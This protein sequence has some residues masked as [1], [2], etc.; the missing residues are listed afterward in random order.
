MKSNES[1]QAPAA[2]SRAEVADRLGVSTQTVDALRDK[3]ELPFVKLGRRVLI[4]A[5]DVDRWLARAA[6]TGGD[7]ATR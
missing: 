6:L 4:Q 2:L 5:A 3:G 7:H 1:K